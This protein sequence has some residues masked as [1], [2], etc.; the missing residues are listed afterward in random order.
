MQAD[1]VIA[2][3]PIIPNIGAEL[4]EIAPEFPWRSLQ[5]FPNRYTVEM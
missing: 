4:L 2:L 1:A 3:V 5:V